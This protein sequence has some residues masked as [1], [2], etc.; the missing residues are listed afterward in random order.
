MAIWKV[1]CLSH[2]CYHH[3]NT[4]STTWLFQ[5]P[6]FALHKHSTSINEFQWVQFFST[7]TRSIT[8]LFFMC[9]SVSDVI[10]RLSLCC[11]LT[12]KFNDTLAWIN[13]LMIHWHEVEPLLPYYQYLPLTLYVNIIKQETLHLEQHLYCLKYASHLIYNFLVISTT[14]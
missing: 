9:V 11:H 2:Y 3:W 5:Y 12:T 4:S 8:H 13:V 7:W 1:A 10:V 14:L 6:L